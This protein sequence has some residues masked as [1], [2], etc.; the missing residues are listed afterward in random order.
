MDTDTL[1]LGTVGL[2][3]VGLSTLPF[4]L[5]QRRREREGAEL[6][7]RALRYGLHEPVSLHPVVDA[8][9]CIGTGAC[10][11]VCPEGVL[12]IRHGQAVALAP[13]SCIGHG[14]CERACPMEAIRL[15]FGTE[16]RGVE[17][18]RIREDF[19][20]NVP[21]LYVIGE[22]G[23]MGL[24]RNA[25][26]QAGQC[27]EAISRERRDVP[28]DIPEVVIVGC[29]PAGL[30]AALHARS[31]GMRYLAL[32]REE[33]LGGT[34][35]HYPRKKLVMTGALKVPGHGKLSFREIRKEELVEVWEEIARG[36]GVE[37]STGETVHGVTRRGDRFEVATSRGRHE[38]A[39]V[40]LAIG[41]RGIPRRLEVP[42]EESLMVAYSLREPEAFR[43][44]RVLVV[45]GG[46][47]AVEAALAL[48]E[49]P[50]TPVWVSYRGAAFG[51]IKHANRERI[52][53][54]IAAGSVQVLWSTRVTEIAPGSVRIADA[55]GTVADLPVDR[56]FVLIG[57]ELPTRFLRECGVEIDVKFGTP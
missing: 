36:T 25:F 22:L 29:G 35:R 14:L 55:N 47:S 38:G 37:V 53:A 40:I 2:L 31:R 12:G 45:G 32:E 11:D 49:Q 5:R 6:E 39:R 44:D 20:T 26:E 51:R 50:G 13:A 33:E 18:P 10:V 15:V 42:G 23:G 8:E 57:G 28:G 24:I 34:V 41:R 46:D 27:I 16:Q 9:R 52:D 21:G 1:I 56:V 54:A 19:E 4:V 3:L 30:A 48:A 7:R 43:G 17:L